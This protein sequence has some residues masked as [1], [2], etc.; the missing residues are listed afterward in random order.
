MHAR[1][2]AARTANLANG[3]SHSFSIGYMSRTNLFL[4]VEVE[5]DEDDRPERLGGEIC[6]YLA[7]FYGVNSAEMTNYSTVDE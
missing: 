1:T 6:R 5:H 3:A 2:D 7:K 4:K